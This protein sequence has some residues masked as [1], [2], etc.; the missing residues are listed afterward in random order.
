M[1]G[2]KYAYVKKFELPDPLLPETYIVVRLDGHGFHRLSQDHDFTKPNDER[3]LQLMDHAARDIM[4]EFKEVV[5]AFGES[6]EYSFLFRKSAAVYNRRHAKILST[7]TSL[8]TSSYVF[9]WARY[10]PET[11]LLYPPSFDGRVILYPSS[12]EVRDY[13]SWRQADT[14]IN[15]LYNTTFWAL[16]QQ[17]GETT[18][19]AHATLR[20][21]VSKTKHE[22]LFSR[23][24]INYNKVSER[25]RKGSIVVREESSEEQ[26]V[27]LNDD[28]CT[29]RLTESDDG[30]SGVKEG[31]MN[32]PKARDTRKIKTSI[33]VL[34][35]DIIGKEFWDTRP[36]LL[37]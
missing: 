37:E 8:F 25:Y 7:I 17:G 20:G 22:I 30:A 13:F 5:L 35:C 15:N 3:A 36:W 12:Q 14:H 10:F 16:V 31:R 4:N 1:A 11:R 23:F 2:T 26:D 27:S 18:T 24:G 33:S 32:Q 9:N 21:T 28:Q 6:D 34:H 19:Q 29:N